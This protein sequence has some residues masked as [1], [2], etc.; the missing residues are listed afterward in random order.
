MKNQVFLAM[1]AAMYHL[2]DKDIRD[3]IEREF[4]YNVSI[5]IKDVTDKDIKK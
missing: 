1:L 4:L 3:L 2:W 5:Y